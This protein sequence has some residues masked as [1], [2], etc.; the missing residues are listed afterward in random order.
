MQFPKMILFDYGETLVHEGTFDGIKGI[1]EVL[2][3]AVK[4]KYNKTAREIYQVAEKINEDL[5]RFD[6]KRKHLFQFEVTSVS[7]YSYLYESQGIS[8]SIPYEEVETIFWNASANGVAMKGIRELLEFLKTKKIRT[9]VV[10][11]ISYRGETLKKHIHELIPNEEFE[12]FIASS[13]YVFRKPNKRIFELALEK[14]C[15]EPNE[16]WYCGDQYE[17]DIV[18]AKKVGLTPIWISEEKGVKADYNGVIISAWDELRKLVLE[19]ENA[20]KNGWILG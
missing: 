14:A 19:K 20:I 17:C 4:N 10:S 15:L 6:P 5:G 16:V 18:G 8:L 12:F 2:K 3:Y 11:N 13:D 7:F 9:G 1:E